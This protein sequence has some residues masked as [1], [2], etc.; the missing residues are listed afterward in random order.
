MAAKREEE[1]DCGA[2]RGKRDAKKGVKLEGYGGGGVNVRELAVFV[3]PAKAMIDK[4]IEDIAYAVEVT[5][6]R[7]LPHCG[8]PGWTEIALIE[9]DKA[10][11]ALEKAV[12]TLT[13]ES[14]LPPGMPMPPVVRRISACER[15]KEEKNGGEAKGQASA[16]KKANADKAPAKK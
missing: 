8:P 4:A 2:C 15:R 10:N 16:A 1:C 7:R 9:L 13:S 3:V 12:K 14:Y 11:E 5:R 6:P